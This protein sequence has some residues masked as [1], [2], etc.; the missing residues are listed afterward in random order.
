MIEQLISKIDLTL[1]GV[2]IINNV[3][4]ALDLRDYVRETGSEL[5]INPAPEPDTGLSQTKFG[6]LATLEGRTFLLREWVVKQY[7][8]EYFGGH[9]WF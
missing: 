5:V 1:E 8:A 2:T 7:F 9:S 4:R 6:H 3:C